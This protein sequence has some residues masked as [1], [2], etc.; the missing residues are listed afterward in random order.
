MTGDYH[1]QPGAVA[2][3][4]GSTSC[5]S[6]ISNCVPTTDFDGNSRPQGGAY[7]IGCYESF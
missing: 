3:D 2:I 5:A 6:S 1:L 4:A 7:D